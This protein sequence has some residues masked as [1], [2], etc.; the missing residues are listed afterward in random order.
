MI[1]P[2]VQKIWDAVHERFP[3]VAS[4]GIYN[5][6]YKR[7]GKGWSEHAW[8]NA[9]DITYAKDMGKVKGRA[10]LDK[11]YAFLAQAKAAKTLPIHWIIWRQPNHYDHIHVVG[12]PKQTGTPPLKEGTTVESEAVK[13]I[14][15]AMNAHGYTD[16]NNRPLK[17]D[18]IVGPNTEFAFNVFVTNKGVLK[19]LRFSGVIE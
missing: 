6:R 10:Y 1:T 18:G 9:W 14:Q 11:I 3:D 19:G 5:R 15:R 17:V 13:M 4:L 8:G 16:A 7:N 2:S 12:E